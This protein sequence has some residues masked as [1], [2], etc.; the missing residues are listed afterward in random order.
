MRLHI[1]FQYCLASRYDIRACPQYNPLHINVAD[2]RAVSINQTQFASKYI[3]H[4][5]FICWK[6]T[7]RTKTLLLQLM[8][9]RKT[10]KLCNFN[11]NSFQ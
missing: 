8:V 3:E 6:Y 10:W 1:Y 11:F 4:F 5:Q 2:W 7:T 9:Y